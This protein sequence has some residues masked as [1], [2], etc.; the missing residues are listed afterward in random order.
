MPE[1]SCGYEVLPDAS[2]SLHLVPSPPWWCSALRSEQGC[3]K[4]AG[5]AGMQLAALGSE[6]R[7][8]SALSWWE[9]CRTEPVLGYSSQRLASNV[10]TTALQREEFFKAHHFFYILA[11]AVWAVLLIQVPKK[12]DGG[13]RSGM[14]LPSSVCSA[15]DR[16]ACRE[17]AAL[18]QPVPAHHVLQSCCGD[19]MVQGCSRGSLKKRWI[20][21][22]YIV[23][24]W[25]D[26][27]EW[28][29]TKRGDAS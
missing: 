23:R 17:H 29:K 15:W 26:K 12:Q 7:A 18:L 1:S 19:G 10:Y 8:R 16:T 14:A 4:A 3:V 11:A 25:Q 20:V 28:F 6:Q 22:F 13:G 27:G 24:P 2:I 21:M 9:M 5:S